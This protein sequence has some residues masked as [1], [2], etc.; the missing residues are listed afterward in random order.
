M[1]LWVSQHWYDPS[2]RGP[3]P[4]SDPCLGHNVRT[5]D[6]SEPQG[7]LW[8][9][10]KDYRTHRADIWAP[11]HRGSDWMSPCVEE[12]AAHAPHLADAAGVI[13]AVADGVVVL[14]P[15]GAFGGQQHVHGIQ[16]VQTPGG[17]GGGEGLCLPQARLG[18]LRPNGRIIGHHHLVAEERMEVA[19]SQA[20]ARAASGQPVSRRQALLAS[21]WQHKFALDGFKPE[22][23]QKQ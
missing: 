19:A 21:R 22:V 12:A 8:S 23:D 16:A 5:G 15:A 10:D 2:V 14:L 3:F 6:L 9:R 11:L 1:W 20:R 7:G 13:E 18:I 17:E 4:P